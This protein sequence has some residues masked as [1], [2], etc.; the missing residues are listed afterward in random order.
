LMKINLSVKILVGDDK[1]SATAEKFQKLR[2]QK[3]DTAI[4]VN[5]NQVAKE[6]SAENKELIRKLYLPSYEDIAKWFKKEDEETSFETEN[7]TENKEELSAD[8]FEEKPK[9]KVEEKPKSNKGRPKKEQSLES[10]EDTV[11][12][13]EKSDNEVNPFE[14]FE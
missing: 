9:V 5:M 3:Y 8:D 10:S 13:D 2:I 4:K 11:A 12:A 6:L 14:N 7:F 1:D